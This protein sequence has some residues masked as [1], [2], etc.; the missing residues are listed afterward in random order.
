M[1]VARMALIKAKMFKHWSSGISDL[2]AV[3]YDAWLQQNLWYLGWIQTD[4]CQ[5]KT[6]CR[7]TN[8]QESRLTAS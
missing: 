3:Q 1:M 8:E 5:T 6:S 7:Q 4:I 2:T